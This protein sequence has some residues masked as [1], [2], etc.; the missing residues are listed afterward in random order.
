[1]SAPKGICAFCGEP[2]KTSDRAAFA[3]TGY[4]RER[5]TGGQNHVVKKARVDGWIWHA[6]FDGDCF[7]RHVIKRHPKPEPL[8]S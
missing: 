3:I 7:E 8:F 1:M 2:V 6:R 4:E 5:E